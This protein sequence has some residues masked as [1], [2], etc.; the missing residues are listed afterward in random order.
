M[1]E[2]TYK[3]LVSQVQRSVFNTLAFH[4]QTLHILPR[5]R[6]L[7]LR[8]HGS[9][10]LVNTV[11]FLSPTLSRI[12]LH[13]DAEVSDQ[14][15]QTFFKTMEFY[16]QNNL[17]SLSLSHGRSGPFVSPITN[18]LLSLLQCAQGLTKVTLTLSAV[19]AGVFAQLATMPNLVIL[20]VNASRHSI[21]SAEVVTLEKNTRAFP[22][23]RE[24]YLSNKAETC[25]NITKAVVS[26]RL[27]TIRIQ[28]NCY[29]VDHS[30]KTLEAICKHSKTLRHLVIE[31][32][33]RERPLAQPYDREGWFHTDQLLSCHALR[34]LS[35]IS[36]NALYIT[37]SLLETMAKAW[38]SI[39]Y[40]SLNPRPS[41]PPDPPPVVFNSNP[42]GTSP[43]GGE[44]HVPSFPTNGITL[45]SLEPFVRETSIRHLGLIFDAGAPLAQGY[46]FNRDTADPASLPGSSLATLDPGYSPLPEDIG[47][48][49]MA[50]SNLFPDAVLGHDEDLSGKRIY[51]SRYFNNLAERWKQVDW[52]V[53]RIKERQDQSRKTQEELANEVKMLRAELRK[54]EDDE[55]RSLH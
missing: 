29:S 31:V 22:S 36:P 15:V 37:P 20:R 54:R 33:D 12:H 32:L 5:L 55:A 27:K 9:A 50:I 4:R 41:A 34:V 21:A 46:S 6:H 19:T 44:A 48:V 40:L 43:A 51:F 14:A 16:G 53:R 42:F 47:P 30:V 18:A 23:L 35:I 38:R 8:A 28:I 39:Q 49:S 13:I 3:D 45:A 1:Q 24:L 7:M 11:V 2:I 52:I 17:R 25:A 10:S 26:P